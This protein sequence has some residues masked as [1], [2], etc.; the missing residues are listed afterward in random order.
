MVNTALCP[1]PLAMGCHP[2]AEC[3]EGQ[4][5]YLTWPFPAVV[6]QQGVAARSRVGI[7]GREV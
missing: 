3:P 4:P 1:L 2:G 5:K 7:G 6:Q